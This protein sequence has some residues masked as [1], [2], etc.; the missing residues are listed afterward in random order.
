MITK[1]RGRE[2][3]SVR[4]QGI[5]AAAE[6]LFSQK[7]FSGTSTR[8]VAV[9]ASVHEAVLF[10]HF[11]SKEELYRATIETK[12]SRN[13]QSALRQMEECASKRDDRGFFEA[14][15]RSLLGRFEDDVS[16]PRLIL[17][18][19][20]DGFEPV[21]AG[22]ERQLR[23]ERPTRRYISTRIRE[24]VFRKMNPDHAVMAFGAMLFGYI[25]R[26]HIIGM[27]KH[28][29]Y[30]RE[31]I[32]QSFVTIFLEGMKASGSS[33]AKARKSRKSPTSRSPTNGSE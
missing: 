4:R 29:S 33:G 28:R 32:V 25:V 17:Y 2:T 31:R 1:R 24:G 21:E 18:T 13:R 27:A 26:Q 7:G 12:L 3:A 22:I 5:L 15:A 20:L 19:A 30:N 23:V 11:S 6:E 14:V 16:I 9:R 8:N 10:R